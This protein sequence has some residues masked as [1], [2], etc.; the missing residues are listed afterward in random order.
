MSLN[1]NAL[2]RAKEPGKIRRAFIHFKDAVEAAPKGRTL[3][4]FSVVA[5]AVAGTMMARRLKKAINMKRF[6]AK[7]DSHF[8]VDGQ[9]EQDGV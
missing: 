4:A 3:I 2:N 1:K 6:L 9:L 7:R 5:A 8:V